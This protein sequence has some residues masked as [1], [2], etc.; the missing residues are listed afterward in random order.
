M[1]RN[2]KKQT[3]AEQKK[4]EL[5]KQLS[6]IY[7]PSSPITDSQLFSGRQQII[8]SLRRH[9]S[10]A[11][12]NFVLYGER[13]VGKTSF[14]KVSFDGYNIE[15][16]NC[17]KNDDFI[18]IFLNILSSRGEQFTEG[19]RKLLADA[20]YKIGSDNLLSVEGKISAEEKEE[21]IAKQRLDLNFVLKKLTKLQNEIDAIVLDE[22]Q[23]IKK[24]EIQTEIIEV[25]KGLADKN[26]KLNIVI[27]GVAD[28][29]TQL[30]T[31]QEYPQYKLR[32]F[33]AKKIP[34]M[35]IEELQD[36][37]DKREELY[38]IKFEKD[39]RR[40][41]A[42]IS[43]G[44]PQYVHQLALYSCVYWLVDNVAEIIEGILQFFGISLKSPTIENINMHIGSKNLFDAVKQF[45]DEFESNYSELA[46]QYKETIE[47]YDKDIVE[48]MVLILAKS[49]LGTMEIE[50]IAEK[51]DNDVTEIKRLIENNLDRIIY[52]FDENRYGFRFPQLI[53]YFRSL[54]YLKCFNKS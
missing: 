36:I 32:H 52:K 44:Y 17:S 14:Y 19:E 50:D 2:R 37:I 13:G 31:S 33:I 16:H 48:K 53:P 9:L 43:S 30:L 20:G 25:V 22:F 35:E 8:Q 45:V 51:S 39:V 47:S 49:R 15:V 3:A 34:K 4:A 54:E 11:G 27:V 12:M 40:W 7:T 28:S 42:E 29:D 5:E 18:T 24:H 10:I 6:K 41:I 1:A 26:I 38:G 21:P 23:N 46:S